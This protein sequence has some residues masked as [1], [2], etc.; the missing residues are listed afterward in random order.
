MIHKD[1]ISKQRKAGERN[2]TKKSD[3]Q[4][5]VVCVGKGTNYHSS[6]AS[7][8]PSNCPP[9]T[10]ENF[11]FIF[12]FAEWLAAIGLRRDLGIHRSAAA[13]TDRAVSN[14]MV[15][16]CLPSLLPQA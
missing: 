4:K 8:T 7:A 16:I 6:T 5:M 14:E 12:G 13:I 9:I 1:R 11:D 15:N 10:F 2:I 3:R